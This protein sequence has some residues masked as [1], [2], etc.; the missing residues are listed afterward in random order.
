MKAIVYDRYGSV[1]VLRCEEISQIPP[2]ENEVLIRVHAASV[3]PLD[4]HFMRGT[5][6]VMRLGTG[7]GKPRIPRLGVDVAGII[8]AIGGKVTRFK[9]GDA[10]FG[11]CRGAFA[12]YVCAPESALATK[13]DE[14]T[15]EHA[16][17]VPIAA[18]T[19]LQG[20][21]DKGR[22]RSGQE[23]LVNGASGGVGTFTVQIAKYF[24]A[25]VTGVCSDRSADLV[26]SLGAD[27][28]VDYT[29]Q[30]F[31]R[32][33]NRYDVFFD[34][35]GNHSLS[36]CRRVLNPRGKY[37]MIGGGAPNDSVLPMAVRMIRMPLMSLFV[38]QS[39]MTLMAKRSQ[40][41]LATIAELMRTSRVTPVIDRC[42]S[43]HEFPDAIRYVEAGHARG[44][45]IISVLR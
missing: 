44:K 14:V 4:W 41:D 13:P 6:R 1:D 27:R 30:D 12:E 26:Q 23:V 17:A 20:L 36:A 32:L 42:Y 40:Q 15:F 25:D 21:R 5:P 19:A 9:P 43:L 28:V 16:A 22:M 35:I 29:K 31:T 39:F 38:S 11:F 45:V 34:C 7:L 24:G 37:I 2:R 18:L 10:V 3:N 8:E 33:G